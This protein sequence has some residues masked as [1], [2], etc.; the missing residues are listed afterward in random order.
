MQSAAEKQAVNVL[1]R[2]NHVNPGLA[3]DRRNLGA[4]AAAAER[5]ARASGREGDR[6][7]ARL[8]RELAEQAAHASAARQSGVHAGAQA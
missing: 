3:R 1:E 4:R 2:H 7:R 5:R 8:A 6:R